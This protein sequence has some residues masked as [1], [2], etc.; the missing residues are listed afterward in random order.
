MVVYSCVY[1]LYTLEYPTKFS[2]VIRVLNLVG[3]TVLQC[4]HTHASVHVLG[5]VTIIAYG[6]YGP[7]PASKTNHFFEMQTSRH[8]SC[9]RH[10]PVQI[11]FDDL[12]INCFFFSTIL[13]NCGSEKGPQCVHTQCTH[14]NNLTISAKIRQK[15]TGCAAAGVHSTVHTQCAHA[16]CTHA[17]NLTIWRFLG[18]VRMATS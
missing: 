18:R 15:S 3:Y 7:R 2:T 9:V 17:N 1:R 14:A 4:V 12:E 5:R 16:Q 8:S 13:K 6:W 11:C 10:E